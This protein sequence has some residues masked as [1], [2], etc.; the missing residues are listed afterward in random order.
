MI[1]SFM[2]VPAD[3]ERKLEKSLASASDALIFDLEDS[4]A[5]SR[6]AGARSCLHRFLLQH[7]GRIDKHV[8]VR[9]NDLTSGMTVNDLAAVMQHRPDGIVL[10]KSISGEDVRCLSYY[11]D[12]FDAVNSRTGSPTR[13]LPIVTETA[14]SLFEFGSY[15]N[16]SPRLMGL[17]WGAEDLSADIGARRRK[18]SGRWTGAIAHARSL[19]L[20]A[21]ANAGVP[22][23][24]AISAEIADLR[25]VESEALE[26]KQDGFAAKAAIHPS[27]VLPINDVFTPSDEELRWAHRVISAFNDGSGV[28]TLDGQMLDRPHMRL[29]ERLLAACSGQQIDVAHQRPRTFADENINA[30]DAPHN[31]PV[32][33]VR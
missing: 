15:K 29:A 8:Y 30:T 31:R 24:D 25:V 27:Q 22:A 33:G 6:K 10:P 11:L 5:T 9:V 17:M 1:R 4:V 13:I 3:S 21:A 16:A 26:A 12:V 32:S 18:S 14:S 28:A 7:R 20:I 23:I 2:F 19:C